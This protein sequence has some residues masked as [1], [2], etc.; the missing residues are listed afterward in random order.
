MPS[1]GSE[2]GSVYFEEKSNE[3]YTIQTV[4]VTVEVTDEVTVEVTIE[5]TIEG[6]T[7]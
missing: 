7:S 4:E 5:V 3:K 6:I 2:P 1:R